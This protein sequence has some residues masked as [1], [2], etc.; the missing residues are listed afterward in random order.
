M[1]T[2]FALASGAGRAGV[3]VIR[4][5]GPLA[6]ENVERFAKPVE[7]RRPSLRIL[8][9]EGEVIDEA[10]VITFPGPH[11]FTGDD[12]VE[13]H[14]HGSVATVAAFSR[15]LA[16]LPG[17]REAR[18]GEFSR[19]ALENERL[20]LT[21]IEG[22]GDLIEAETEEQ[23]RQAV[24]VLSGEVSERYQGWRRLLIRSSAL[25]AATIDFADEDVPV[26]V[27][28]EVRDII[29]QALQDLNREVQ[30][31]GIAER[32]TNGFEVAIVGPPNAGKSTLLNVLAGRDA[33]I[34][35]ERAGTTRDVIEVRMDLKGLAVTLLD[36]A[37]L[38]ETDD[39]IERE[40]VE[41]AKSR[42][43]LAD[44]RVILCEPGSS[45]AI[46]P[47]DDDIVVVP[48]SDVRPGDFS[49]LTGDG[50][51]A[52]VD[53][54]SKVLTDRLGKI[55]VATKDR[56]RHAMQE[57]IS[58]LELARD[59]LDTAPEQQEITAE[60]IRQAVLA[61]DALVGA[62]GVEDLLDEVFSSFCIGK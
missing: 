41:R 9:A 38:R 29:N 19:R 6:I 26:D 30:G 15:A 42:S 18:A 43:R 46:P 32:V 1:D 7:P 58:S 45:P 24:R 37:G 11:S 5:S 36:T 60:H 40:G 12:V 13:Y 51:E 16:S 57:A 33:A 27:T 47:A 8:R 2:I 25:L 61:L 22:L 20:D 39:A 4:V 23:R 17:V 48:K 28:P 31:V 49:A 62:V 56:H 10:L 14:L 35:S 54:I 52:L 53:R 50:I 21:Q 3:S 55:G 59:S 34:T 44:L